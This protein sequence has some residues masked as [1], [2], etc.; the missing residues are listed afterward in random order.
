MDELFD[1]PLSIL[2]NHLIP[3]AFV[4]IDELILLNQHVDG[5]EITK[6]RLNPNKNYRIISIQEDGNGRVWS[7]EHDI[8]EFWDKADYAQVEYQRLEILIYLHHHKGVIIQGVEDDF[9]KLL[10]RQPTSLN[11]SID[12]G[13]LTDIKKNLIKQLDDSLN[14]AQSDKYGRLVDSQLRGE[15]PDIIQNQYDKKTFLVHGIKYKPSQLAKKILER[16][17]TQHYTSDYKL[18]PSPRGIAIDELANRGGVEPA[19]VYKT[20]NSINRTLRGKECL[21]RIALNKAKDRV[22]LS[23]P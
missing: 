1:L 7:P 4:L 6:F 13:T 16:L 23:T 14:S 3:K 12:I 20:V 19:E 11:L 21:L 15:L 2:D 10:L 5:K 22:Y 8:M 18:R 9:M 17:L